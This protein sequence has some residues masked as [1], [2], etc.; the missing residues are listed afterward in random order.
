[1]SG[2]LS[3]PTFAALV[4]AGCPTCSAKRVVIEALLVE[5]VPLLGG[6]VYGSPSW[7]YKGE[8][9]VR[10]TYRVGCESCKSE[11]FS[12]SACPRCGAPGGVQRALEQESAFP[13][14]RACEHCGS[15]QLTAKAFA[16]ARVVYEG[17]RADKP[18]P[19]AAPE[20]PGF[21]A[22]QTECKVCQRVVE[23]RDPCPLCGG[24][25]HGGAA[26]H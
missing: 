15:E 18:R 6:E 9:F 1:M 20:E 5:K 10:G 21:H 14:A 17:K 3:E 16:S 26:E 19:Q 11:L 4:E 13:L 22:F 2:P 12:A 25:A 24:D 8:D 23:T 7:A